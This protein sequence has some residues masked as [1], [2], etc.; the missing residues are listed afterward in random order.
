MPPHRQAL[1]PRSSR[2]K[3][4]L[5]LTWTWTTHVALAHEPTSISPAPSPSLAP[6]AS[7][8][9]G[10]AAG[11]SAATTPSAATAPSAAMTP[12][13]PVTPPLPKQPTNPPAPWTLIQTDPVLDGTLLVLTIGFAQ[14]TGSLFA[15][16][17]L[18]PERPGDT[19]SI[20]G[21]D[22]FAVHLEVDPG[23]SGRSNAG[24]YVAMG[25]AAFDTVATGFRDGAAT[26]FDD[27]VMYG[28]SLAISSSLASVLKI[29]VR[30]PRPLAYREQARLDAAY[31]PNAPSI[32][33]T[34]N[35]LSFV[36]AQASLTAAA[37]ATYLAFLRA[38]GTWRPWITRGGGLLLT[39]GVRIERVRAGAHFPTDVI[40]GAP[41]GGAVGVLVPHLHLS[42]PHR[43]WALGP[44]PEGAPPGA[45]LTGRF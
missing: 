22:G 35:V 12:S 32:S 34:D 28:E 15:S 27:A 2:W 33:E 10:V 36:S 19:S 18:K 16:G 23:A 5:A 31:G 17:E 41:L 24:L 8:A 39:T 1:R 25:Y 44:G 6:A 11:P 45:C 3:G 21:F 37:T 9:P 14:V 40:A 43:M 30:R 42:N 26:G 4:L 29:A 38:R 20:L 7:S 13:A